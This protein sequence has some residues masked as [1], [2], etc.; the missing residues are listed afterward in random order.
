MTELLPHQQRLVEE[1]DELRDRIDKLSAFMAS[2]MWSRLPDA[3][4]QL[5]VRQ[6][7]TM[8][9]YSLALR[10]RLRLWGVV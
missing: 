4:R 8:V 5:M 9:S 10:D 6:L 7:R 1:R 2:P 3:E